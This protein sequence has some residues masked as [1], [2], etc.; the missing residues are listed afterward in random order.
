MKRKFT[1]ILMCAALAGCAQVNTDIEPSLKNF[2]EP[3]LSNA[4]SEDNEYEQ[5]VFPSQSEAYNALLSK[6][7]EE[8]RYGFDSNMRSLAISRLGGKQRMLPQIRPGAQLSS[9]G[10]ARLTVEVRQIV[11]DGGVYRAQYHSDDHEA[12]LRQVQLLR[13]LNNYASKDI[14]T[15][16]TY[17]ENVEKAALLSD[18]SRHLEAMLDKANARAKGGVGSAAEASLFALK[19]YEIQADAEIARTDAKADL[20]ALDVD[21]SEFREAEFVFDNAHL[22]LAVVEAIAARQAA[23]S[24]LALAKAQRNPQ[25]ALDGR[26]GLDPFTGLPTTNVALDV[27]SEPIAWG[28]N[29]SVQRAEEDIRM[30]SHKLDLAVRDAERQTKRL[31]GRI[32]ALESQLT[33]TEILIGKA[34]ARFD[35]FQGQFQAGTSQLTDAVSLVET[36]RKTLETK[37]TLKFQI[38]DLQRQLAAEGGHFWKFAEP[39]T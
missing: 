18:L 3:V 19:L 22:P 32:D 6:K 30:A 39:E 2:A 27:N 10:N 17:R 35:D 14:E 33:Q 28:G 24:A 29:T 8:L 13:K 37:V 4:E 16:L 15:F 36:L 25:V 26:M 23:K 38:L 12:V 21:V 9:S 5:F 31:R 1:V 7:H 11:F 34:K 20:A